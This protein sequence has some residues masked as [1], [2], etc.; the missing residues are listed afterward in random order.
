[1]GA[2]AQ[3][4]DVQLGAKLGTNV[5]CGQS[6]LREA[7]R[8]APAF[9]GLEGGFGG[10]LGG[11]AS[12]GAAP[13]V[14]ARP[15][16]THALP[17]LLLLLWLGVPPISSTEDKEPEAQVDEAAPAIGDMGRFDCDGELRCLAT[18]EAP[19]RCIEP[20]DSLLAGES[21]PEL[22]MRCMMPSG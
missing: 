19:P 7:Q 16:W 17:E 21:S 2:E 4:V 10:K 14:G 20:A 3:P 12:R 15:R 6:S 1:M 13:R 9:G 22:R 18:T 5:C 8:F 11:L